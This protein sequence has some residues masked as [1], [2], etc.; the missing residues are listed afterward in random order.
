MKLGSAQIMV[1][2][3]MVGRSIAVRQV[4]RQLG[5]DEATLR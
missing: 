3:E 4:A 1:A 2:H 5:V